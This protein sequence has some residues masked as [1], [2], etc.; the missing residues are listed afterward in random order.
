MSSPFALQWEWLPPFDTS[1]EGYAFASL[2]IQVEGCVLSELEDYQSQT[3]RKGM[4]VSAYPLGMFFATN[5]WRLRWEP[6]NSR[7]L[8][9]WRLR[10]NLAAAGEGY[11]WPD[12]SFAR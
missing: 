11:V 1:A 3:I 12:V 4:F 7:D 9:Q 8:L 6:L 5:W 2:E 10:H